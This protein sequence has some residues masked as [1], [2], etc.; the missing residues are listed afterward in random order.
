MIPEKNFVLIFA[1]KLWRYALLTFSSLAMPNNLQQITRVVTTQ[2]QCSVGSI[3]AICPRP[4][5]CPW[6]KKFYLQNFM[7]SHDCIV[8]EIERKRGV[9]TNYEVVLCYACSCRF[10]VRCISINRASCG[11]TF[12]FALSFFG[13]SSILIPVV[14]PE[15]CLDLFS[16]TSCMLFDYSEALLLRKRFSLHRL[17]LERWGERGSIV[18]KSPVNDILCAT[19]IHVRQNVN[20]LERPL[21]HVGKTWWASFC[22]QAGIEH[23]C[24]LLDSLKDL[25]S[26]A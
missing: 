11:K 3:T 16:W 19:S 21:L 6:K 1:N 14:Q 25:W 5:R 9:W 12:I 23:M 13:M 20:T 7:V 2:L 18:C 26:E 4:V 10:S 17:Q 22:H 8:K 15:S 24:E